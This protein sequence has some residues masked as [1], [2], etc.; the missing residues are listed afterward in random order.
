MVANAMLLRD[1]H[2]TDIANN[3]IEAVNAVRNFTYD[4][5]LM[6]IQMPEMGGIEATR[7]IRKLQDESGHIPIIALTAHALSGMR[8]EFLEA[9][10][11]DF[12]AKPIDNDELRDALT[13]AVARFGR[14]VAGGEAA[15]E[16]DAGNHRPAERPGPDAGENPDAAEAVADFLRKIDR[17]TGTDG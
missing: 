11:D 9:G 3:G 13:R 12:I 14:R 17:I 1:G 7:G 8:E 5:I 10:M 15:R 2:R 4:V 16:A 6:D